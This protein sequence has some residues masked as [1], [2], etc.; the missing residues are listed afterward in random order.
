[1]DTAAAERR[2]TSCYSIVLVPAD[3]FLP[4]LEHLR[5]CFYE[6]AWALGKSCGV[7]LTFTAKPVHD[8]T[9]LVEKGHDVAVAEQRW[10]AVRRRARKIAEHTIDRGL[11]SLAFEQMEY[12]SMTVLSIPW[13]QVQVEMAYTIGAGGIMHNK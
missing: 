13:V 11:A 7:A 10:L 12:S 3:V 4:V 8:V 2:V 1:M 9:K 5:R 6:V